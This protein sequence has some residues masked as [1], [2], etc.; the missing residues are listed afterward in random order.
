MARRKQTTKQTETTLN[1]FKINYLSKQQYDDAVKNGQINQNELYMTPSEESGGGVSSWNDIKDKPS[2]FPPSTH[3]HTKYEVGLSNVDNT[4]DYEKNV[5]Y[6]N[7]AGTIS[8]TLSIS[9]GGTGAI[10]KKDARANLGAVNVSINYYE[11]SSSDQ[12]EGDIWL[13]RTY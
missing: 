8:E 3:Q 4:A 11:P 1:E 12:N 6:A 5:S 10:N 2:T 13:C 9:K 7:T